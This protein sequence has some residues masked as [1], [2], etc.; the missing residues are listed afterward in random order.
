MGQER[1]AA[2][3]ARTWQF[4]IGL[5]VV[6]AIKV[7]VALQLDAHPLLQPDTG[8]D[9]TAYVSLAKKVVAGDWA[10]GPGLYYVSPLY[11]YFLALVYAATKSFTAARV[12]QALLGTASVAFIFLTA[13]DWYGRRAAWIAAALAALTGIF[14]YYEALILQSSLDTFL[15]AAALWLLTLALRRDAPRFALLAGVAFGVATLNRPNMLIAAIAVA[16]VLFATRRL[17][18]GALILVGVMA[19]IAP[20]TIRNVVVAHQWSLISSHGGI[21]FFIGNGPGA[22]GYF[23]A[24]PGMP[25]T[26]EGLARDARNVAQ[27]TLGRPLTDAEASSY[28]TNLAWTSIRRDPAAWALLL[29]E[30]TYAVANTAHVSAPFSDTVYAYD[31]STLLRFCFVG[32][33]LLVPLGLFGLLRGAPRA[34]RASYFAWLTFVPAY[35]ASVILFFITE[36]YKLPL[37][38][39]AAIGA[40]AGVEALRADFIARRTRAFVSGAVVVIAIGVL[41]NWPL[42]LDDGRTEERVRMAEYEAGRGDV[43]D[44]ERWTALA[45]SGPIDPASIHYRVG[46]QLLNSKETLQ[47]I[48]HLTLAAQC[49][50]HNP[51]IEYLLG[52][53]LLGAG[54]PRDAVAHLREAIDR[55]VDVPLAGYD[56]AVALEESGDLPGAAR[57]LRGVKPPP[58]TGAAVWLQLGKRAAAVNAPDLAEGFFRRA[59]ALAP[60]LAVAHHL[61]AIDLLMLGRYGEAAD[62]FTTALR[63]QPHNADALAML[64][65]CEQHLGRDPEAREHAEA[66]LR[67]APQQPIALQVESSLRAR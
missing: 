51:R 61:L 33:W 21:N 6:F 56:L 32:P 48:D 29:L 47:A 35:A 64:A 55:H 18:I 14:T 16:I 2:T 27:T 59:I 7:T 19:G 46:A 12:V 58:N 13:R 40:G 26:I 23:H 30:K 62:E 57:A 1:A 25:S 52:H 45:L 10:L 34:Q 5:G 38:V 67:L 65:Y 11:I 63:Y 20:V 66:A 44:A 3:P 28:Y 31:A 22:T 50:P 36:R 24:V 60:K 8:L 37:Y 42:H 39:V 43:A 17:R 41:A 9:T 54:R 53:A 49:A 15:A 4:A